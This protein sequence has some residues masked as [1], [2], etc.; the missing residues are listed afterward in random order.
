MK[1]SLALLVL[2]LSVSFYGQKKI[3]YTEDFKELRSTEGATYYSIYED[4]KE[5]TTRT[6]YFIDGTKRN[7]DE[8]SNLKKR[9]KDGNSI[10]WF[11]N[12]NKEKE[13]IYKKGKIDGVSNLYYEN[14]QIKRSENYKNGEFIDGKCFNENGTEIT[15][16]PYYV[17]PEFPG[18]IKEFYKYVA[19]NFKSPNT[20]KGIMKIEFV[21]ETDGT[22]KDIKMVQWINHGMSTEALR[23]LNN[24]PLWIPGKIDGKD[25]RVKYGIPITIN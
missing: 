5:G 4:T 21:V 17:Q 13:L 18:G 12:G 3:Y 25:A 7:Y 20:S 19:K 23:V 9:I 24:S 2:L 10:T 15:F 11:K 6:T 14:S 8:F 16:F 22:L 1:K